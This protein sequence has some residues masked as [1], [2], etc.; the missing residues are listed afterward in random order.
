MFWSI[1]RLAV[2]P[3]PTF[4]PPPLSLIH[5]EDLIRLMLLAAEKG[6][7]IVNSPPSTDR[8]SRPAGYYFAAAPEHPNY[9]NIGR[10]VARV[11]GRQ[12]VV[13]LHMAEP[14]P[15]LAAAVSQFVARLRRQPNTL[16][17]DKMREA[18]MPSWACSPQ[19]ALEDL[20]FSPAFPLQERMRQTAEWYRQQ[21]WL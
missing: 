2:H 20:D 10:M 6:K 15:W 3:I 21:G 5:T 13:L 16:N 7:R 19:A 11:V 14:L 4:A 18:T 12:R 17:V 8:R 9:A 1:S